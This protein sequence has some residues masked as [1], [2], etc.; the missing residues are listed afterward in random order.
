M[1]SSPKK[2]NLC[3]KYVIFALLRL[4]FLGTKITKIENN[5][6]IFVAKKT[7]VVKKK[8]FITDIIHILY[9]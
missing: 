9:Q 8:T 7:F 4:H 5:F 2:G 3:P 6:L 1:S